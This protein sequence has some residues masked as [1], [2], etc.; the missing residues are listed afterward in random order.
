MKNISKELKK[1]KIELL[2][3]DLN[4]ATTRLNE[5]LAQP[6]TTFNQDSAIK[7]FE[8]TFEM[9]WKIMKAICEYEGT[10]VASPR[11]SIRQIADIGLIDDPQ[12]WIK[13]LKSRNLTVHT[14]KEEIA[15]KVYQS[16]KKFVP[17]VKKLIS[18]VE[19]YLKK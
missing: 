17:F 6:P 13:F 2:Y 9:A 12:A 4:S 3:K 8:F 16:V 14:Y 11:Q 19:E 5:A 10:K 1:E 15:Q 7:R 18:S